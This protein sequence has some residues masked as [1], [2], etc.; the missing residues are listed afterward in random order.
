[1]MPDVLRARM[2]ATENEEREKEGK[3]PVFHWRSGRTGEAKPE[4]SEDSDPEG[5]APVE[6]DMSPWGSPEVDDEEGRHSQDDEDE[7]RKASI[8]RERSADSH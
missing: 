6:G 3:L 2:S 7:G 5:S 8:R 1:M 4:L